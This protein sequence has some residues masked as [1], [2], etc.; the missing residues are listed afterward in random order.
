MVIQSVRFLFSN[1]F[2]PLWTH[3]RTLKTVPVAPPPH[4]QTHNTQKKKKRQRERERERERKRKK[5][6]KH[7][8]ER[9]K[10]NKEFAPE[11]QTACLPFI[12]V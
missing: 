12:G 7:T 4:T 10:A 8:N 6:G 9:G 1:L 11:L 2:G 5:I 3:F